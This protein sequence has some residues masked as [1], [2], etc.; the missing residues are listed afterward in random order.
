MTFLQ[1]RKSAGRYR[2]VVALF[3]VIVDGK[4]LMWS[5]KICRDALGSTSIQLTSRQPSMS[6]IIKLGGDTEV[7]QRRI[8]KRHCRSSPIQTSPIAAV[9]NRI[10]HA[11]GTCAVCYGESHQEPSSRSRV[12]VCIKAFPNNFL[13][14]EK[15]ND[16][17]LYLPRTWEIV[18]HDDAVVS[19]CLHFQI[20]HSLVSTQ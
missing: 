5:T 18:P 13:D 9:F 16:L 8:A 1:Y 14:E 19:F 6:Q 20:R 3:S 2:D 12:R 10:F 7:P 17:K 11:E 15:L 4:L